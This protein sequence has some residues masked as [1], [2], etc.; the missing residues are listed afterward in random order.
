[1]IRVYASLALSGDQTHR[2]RVYRALQFQ[3]RSQLFIGAHNETRS[4]TMGVSNPVK[5]RL[6]R[7][8]RRENS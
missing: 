3:K 6:F 1:L 5:D 2:E 4:V 8:L 7:R